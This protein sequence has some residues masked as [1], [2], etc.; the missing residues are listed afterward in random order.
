MFSLVKLDLATVKNT[1][2]TAKELD[3]KVRDY[4]KAN[5]DKAFTDLTA[6]EAKH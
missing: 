6:E 3:A 5:A 1:L 2:D 4:V